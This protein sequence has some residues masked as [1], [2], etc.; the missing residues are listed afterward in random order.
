MLLIKKATIVVPE[1]RH[2][3]KQRDVLIKDGLIHSIK[4]KI[5]RPKSAQEVNANGAYLSIGWMDIGAHSGDPGFEHRE[6]LQS[7][8]SA[9]AAGGFTAIAT[10]P[11]TNPPIH[12]KS[13]V[14]Y[15]S[16]DNGRSLVDIY[17]LGAISVGCAGKEITE[18]YDMHEHGAVAF[19]DGGGIQHAGLLQRAL[20]Y[21]KSFDGLIMNHPLDD[22]LAK[23][24]LMH[25][26]VVSTSLGM[27]GIPEISETMMLQRDLTLLEYTD[28]RL[29][30]SNI[31][32]AESVR[33]VA[34]AQK[35]GK[36]VSCSV[37]A[38]N[39]L[40]N[41]ESL[42]GFD[43]QAKVKPVLRSEKD[44]KALIK[45]VK[46]GVVTFVSSNHQPLEM[47]AKAVEFPRASFGSIGLETCFAVVN[48]AMAGQLTAEEVHQLFAKNPRRLLKIE[49]PELK[50]GAEANL[51]LF[52]L[53]E[54]WSFG[55]GHIRS[56]SQNTPFKGREFTGRPLGTVL[57][58][59][60]YFQL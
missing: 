44:R 33:K 15:L 22:T 45:G 18:L 52:S 57:R 48:T 32:S 9:A 54:T 27:K 25:E 42:L 36:K 7:L 5:D 41:D 40:L 46:N 12:S 20:L 51:T 49:I 47:E 23:E 4:A 50:E 26:G 2:H 37:P 3:Q 60:H 35:A 34:A 59:K 16:V 39:L 43:V 31:S 28:S 30:L 38:M 55:P 56:K 29:H 8:K 11:N 19:T 24:G 6:D 14:N 53:D 10:M 1:S 17:P 13:E 21:A 58:D